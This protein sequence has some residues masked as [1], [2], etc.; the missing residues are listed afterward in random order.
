MGKVRWTKDAN[1]IGPEGA[2]IAL[3]ERNLLNQKRPE[4][5]VNPKDN[6]RMECKSEKIDQERLRENV[7][8]EGKQIGRVG[9]IRGVETRQNKWPIINI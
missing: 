1:D 2:P 4:G 8:K 9:E 7:A 5:P 6:N 3:L